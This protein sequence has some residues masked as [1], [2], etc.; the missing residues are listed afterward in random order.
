MLHDCRRS[1]SGL[2]FARFYLAFR[3]RSKVFLVPGPGVARVVS[4]RNRRSFVWKVFLLLDVRNAGRFLGLANGS[5][6]DGLTDSG[7][8]E[9][10]VG[11]WPQKRTMLFGFE[12]QGLTQYREELREFRHLHRCCAV[13]A[14]LLHPPVFALRMNEFLNG[15]RKIAQRI[16]R[17]GVLPGPVGNLLNVFSLRFREIRTGRLFLDGFDESPKSQRLFPV[18]DQFGDELSFS[19]LLLRDSSFLF[20]SLPLLLLS[21]MPFLG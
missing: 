7:L 18:S 19:F 6:N 12:A 21:A 14:N 15:V 2:R 16:Q 8:A 11:R 20:F 3:F 10:E 1:E 5:W 9:G 4:D 17:V 13:K